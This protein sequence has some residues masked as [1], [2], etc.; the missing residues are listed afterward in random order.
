MDLIRVM[1]TPPQF[2]EKLRQRLS[3]DCPSAS[4][5]PITMSD[6]ELLYELKS[7]GCPGVGDKDEID[8]VLFGKRDLFSLFYKVNAPE[9][10][11]EQREL[12]IKAI[13]AWTMRSLMPHSLPVAHAKSSLQEVVLRSEC[14]PESCRWPPAALG[15]FC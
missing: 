13:T 9:M 6:T 1:V 14:L 3:K 11:S 10:T 15:L 12:G 4:I 5:T 7:G 2:L 8:R